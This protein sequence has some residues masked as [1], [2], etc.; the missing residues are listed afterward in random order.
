[1]YGVE[2]QRK[3]ILTSWRH[4]HTYVWNSSTSGQHLSRV[5][6]VGG[7]LPRCSDLRRISLWLVPRSSEMCSLPAT[8][9]PRYLAYFE[10]EQC[11]NL[12]N[13]GMNKSPHGGLLNRCDFKVLQFAVNV[14]ETEQCWHSTLLTANR[15]DWRQTLAPGYCKW[16]ART[17]TIYADHENK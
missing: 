2:S 5:A 7:H 11:C 17:T 3:T 6:S 13:A 1:M 4:V 14:W 8:K 10:A 15:I 16:L 9:I 12:P